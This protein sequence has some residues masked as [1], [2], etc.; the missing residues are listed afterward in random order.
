MRPTTLRWDNCLFNE[1]HCLW[2]VALM[3]GSNWTDINTA[4][5]LSYDNKD[6]LTLETLWTCRPKMAGRDLAGNEH[7][8]D[9]QAKAVA[10]EPASEAPLGNSVLPPRP[11]FP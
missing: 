2:T 3:C 5:I 8:I 6:S 10:V 4:A 9:S 7:R 1:I 11:I